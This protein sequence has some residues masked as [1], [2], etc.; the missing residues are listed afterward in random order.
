M[1]S[2]LL[3][4]LIILEILETTQRNYFYKCRCSWKSKSSSFLICKTTKLVLK[5]P[6]FCRSRFQRP[7]KV[8]QSNLRRKRR[9]QSLDWKC[10][11]SLQTNNN[12][13][14]R[15]S[16]TSRSGDGRQYPNKR[17]TARQI[18][19]IGNKTLTNYIISKPPTRFKDSNR[20]EAA[21]ASW[22][23][24]PVQFLLPMILVSGSF[25]FYS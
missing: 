18:R 5:T 22:T 16:R 6:A 19:L 7:L 15:R 20:Q 25:H 13:K 10:S 11:T 2:E 8:C 21:A 3:F 4:N 1:Y 9:L 24:H 23:T 12:I 14:T 17:R